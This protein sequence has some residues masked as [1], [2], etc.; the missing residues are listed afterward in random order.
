VE[1][2]ITLVLF[3]AVMF[4][5]SSLFSFVR[6][7]FSSVDAQA[8]SGSEVERFFLV[9]DKELSLASEVTQP[10]ADARSNV[11]RFYAANGDEIGY[12]FNEAGNLTRTDFSKKKTKTIMRGIKEGSF[13]RFSRG[14]VQVFVHADAFSALTAVHVWN[15][16]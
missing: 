10:A 3:A 2:V 7:T 13:S 9:L 15:L 5:V 12:E 6:R 4:T 11:L 16:P 8:A 1:F 14:L